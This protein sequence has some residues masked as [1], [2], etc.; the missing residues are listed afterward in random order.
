MRESLRHQPDFGEMKKKLFSSL[1]VDFPFQPV[2]RLGFCEKKIKKEEKQSLK[3]ITYDDDDLI[4]IK[5]IF[6]LFEEKI[7]SEDE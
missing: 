6:F 2:H 5:Q 1:F 4:N 7:A 3:F